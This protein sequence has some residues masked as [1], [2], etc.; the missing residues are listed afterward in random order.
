MAFNQTVADN[1]KKLTDAQK[2]TT[3]DQRKSNRNF[4]D[5]IW[6]RLPPA[7]TLPWTNQWSNNWGSNNN[8]L[9]D[10]WNSIPNTIV[11]NWNTWVMNW[12][13]Y[14]SAE[15][16]QRARNLILNSNSSQNNQ[17]Q[18][19][20]MFQYSAPNS[21]LYTI[22]SAGNWQYKFARQDWSTFTWDLSTV[23]NTINEWN[24]SWSWTTYSAAQKNYNDRY[25]NTYWVKWTE[26]KNVWSDIPLPEDTSNWTEEDF[27]EFDRRRK[28]DE[29]NKSM[30][31]SFGDLSFDNATFKKL[32]DENLKAQLLKNAQ[33]QDTLY[34]QKAESDKEFALVKGKFDE[35]QQEAL[36]RIDKM[37][38]EW[39]NNF[40]E[41]QSQNKEYYKMQTEALNSRVWWEQSWVADSLA[42]KWINEW[43]I[44]NAISK[45]R[46]SHLWQ[47]NKLLENNINIGRQL[48]NDYQAFFQSIQSQRDKWSTEDVRLLEKKFDYAKTI[49]DASKDLSQWAINSAFKPY[50]D[51]M[52]AMTQ[53]ATDQMKYQAVDQAKIDR[54]TNSNT[55]ERKLMLM[56]MLWLDDA[57]IQYWA[58]SQF[59]IALLD[60]AVQQWSLA[61]AIKMLYKASQLA[62]TSWTNLNSPLLGA[63][64]KWVDSSKWNLWDNTKP[65][66]QKLDVSSNTNT[67]PEI[68]KSFWN[69]FDINTADKSKNN[70]VPSVVYTWINDFLSLWN[71]LDRTNAWANAIA[72]MSLE[73]IKKL[74]NDVMSTSVSES[75][76]W[77]IRYLIAKELKNRQ[78]PKATP[79]KNTSTYW[80]WSVA[81]IWNK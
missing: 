64:K 74:N 33:L 28:V 50:E 67:N 65:E 77:P 58:T 18:N 71:F 68:W 31:K 75:A 11:Q 19:Q 44:W 1:R 22:E 7:P 32:V 27:E 39:M 9:L 51:A 57:T 14:S 13:I 70:N 16:A 56:A 63:A 43:V 53:W 15:A 76:R 35:Y 29:L 40:N 5:S 49:I 80:P 42:A 61:D 25:S 73:E 66:E 78:L 41:L 52:A 8:W 47:Y 45:V 81:S 62:S 30:A 10:Y 20:S 34:N 69:S 59:D 21:K 26:W 4:L 6:W 17:S 38:S 2:K 60:K 72:K 48:N 3:Y 36:D 79:S 55:E 24:P 46:D 12:N 54:Y 37:E 23:I